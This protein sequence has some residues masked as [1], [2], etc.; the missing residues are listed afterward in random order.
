MQ[1]NH[2]Y[3]QNLN[4]PQRLAELAAMQAVEVMQ[5][6]PPTPMQASGPSGLE[7]YLS[8][9]KVTLSNRIEKA[10][11]THAMYAWLEG[12]WGRFGNS[13]TQ[14]TN[15][16]DRTARYN[17][18]MVILTELKRLHIEYAASTSELASHFQTIH[19]Y[20]TAMSKGQTFATT[21]I[22]DLCYDE[23]GNNLVLQK[24]WN[25][26]VNANKVIEGRRLNGEMLQETAWLNQ[27]MI[28]MGFRR[29]EGNGFGARSALP[30]TVTACSG[31][32]S[33]GE[34]S[35]EKEGGCVGGGGDG[36]GT[37]GGGNSEGETL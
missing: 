28:E 26:D 30:V 19:D 14:D 11:A 25:M 18:Y 24:I 32:D 21:K 29:W 8:E 20:R 36:G 12:H 6:P 31:E 37:A 34:M 13:F 27:E 1:F 17:R 3:Q 16:L 33:D 7:T 9:M 22:H 5:S 4:S 15:R 10:M 35:G 23:K 2:H